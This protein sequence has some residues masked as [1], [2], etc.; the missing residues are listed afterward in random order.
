MVKNKKRLLATLLCVILII[1]AVGCGKKKA[2]SDNKNNYEEMPEITLT[3]AEVNGA[4]S[5][6][7]RVGQKFKEEVERLS[8]GKIKIDFR[9]DG[10]MGEEGN[11]LPYMMNGRGRVDIIRVSAFSF[12]E[13]GCEKAKLLSIPY[14]FANREHFWDFANSDLAKEFLNEY[15]E[16]GLG[17][18]GLFYGEEGFRHFFTTKEVNSIEDLK[19][20]SI[21]IGTD[22]IMMGMV[23]ALGAEPMDIAFGALHAALGAGTVIGAEQPI[24]NYQSN[25]F[26][27][28]APNMI[29]DG[30]T[31]G[32]IQVVIAE[33]TWNKL[34]AEQQDIL[35]QVSKLAAAYNKQISAEAENKVLE[36][37]KA[38]GVKITE[39]NDVTPWQEAC[40]DLSSQNT[41]ANKELY[42]KIID[43]IK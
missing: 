9:P 26:H 19:G 42:Q 14:T 8:N 41:S 13:Y 3:Y 27:E 18:R 22:P 6:S 37:L 4:N 43:M 32:A 36:E 7:G 12:T 1:S 23:K 10:Q 11:I 29:L 20:I 31:L 38:A 33:D 21:R 34:T 30:H 24:A 5:I 25:K 16:K 17:V 40:K 15:V 2:T 28:V 39:V 35:M